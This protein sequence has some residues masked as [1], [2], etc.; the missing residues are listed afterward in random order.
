MCASEIS[1][2]SVRLS[3]PET[4]ECLLGTSS[5]KEGAVPLGKGITDVTGTASRIRRNS[6]TAVYY[7]EREA[8][9]T[10]QY[11]MKAGVHLNREAG[12]SDFL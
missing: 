4:F 9:R 8:F 12:G 2:L 10:E 1:F 5:P 7:S 11:D 3:P 6:G